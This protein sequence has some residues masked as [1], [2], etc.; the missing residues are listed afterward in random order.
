[1]VSAWTIGL[2][3]LGSVGCNPSEGSGGDRVKVDF[4]YT[5][6]GEGSDAM[7]KL[8]DEF[9][10][11]QDEIYVNGLAQ[12]DTQKQMTAIVGGNPPDLA[13]LPDEI[14]L[15]S[16]AEKGAMLPLDDYIQ[17]NG[18]DMEDYLPAAREAVTYKRKTYGLP[19]GMNTWMLYYNKDL[20]QEA[21][22]DGPPKTIQ[23]LRKYEDKLSKK[24][25]G[26]LVTLGLWPGTTPHIWMQSFEGRLW[27]PEKKTVTPLDPGFKA[28]VQLSEDIWQKHG[29]EN[30]DRLLAG[31]GTYGSPQDPFATG[32][33][34][35]TLDGEWLAPLLEK[36][37]PQLNYD[38]APVPYD[39]NSPEAENAGYIN[40]NLLYIPKGADQPDAAWKFMEWLTAKEKMVEFD[41]AIGNL[42][43]RQSAMDDPIFESVPKFDRFLA[44][45]NSEKMEPLPSLPF[46]EKYMGEIHKQIDRIN[47]GKV[48]LEQGLQEVEKEIQPLV[49]KMEK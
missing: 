38:V 41:T 18:Y 44:Y 9:N 48:S 22:F 2:V 27:D 15:S 20:L 23:E 32:K 7:E 6:L 12:G 13:S 37:A 47:R 36:N 46:M 43:P 1:M 17:T 25:D 21:G 11:S 39:K 42:P 10:R 40:V 26:R 29:P 49:D 30:I 24:K 33:Y 31:N 28:S 35:M 3:L 5:W 45:A 4:W 16:W 8:I 14:N 34:A 19:L